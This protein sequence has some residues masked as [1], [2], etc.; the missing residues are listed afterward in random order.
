MVLALPKCV[1]FVL[2]MLSLVYATDSRAQVQC[3]CLTD[4]LMKM[5]PLCSLSPGHCKT[6]NAATT[7]LPVAAHLNTAKA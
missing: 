6:Y 7:L 5:S 3:S 1:L 2:F 4:H